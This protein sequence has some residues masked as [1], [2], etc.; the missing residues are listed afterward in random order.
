MIQY[1]D[2]DI[3]VVISLS[4]DEPDVCE[5]SM[6]LATP[7]VFPVHDAET[8][9]QLLACQQFSTFAKLSFLKSVDTASMV[10]I[11]NLV[12]GA[13]AA[14]PLDWITSDVLS[15][16]FSDLLSTMDKLQ[17]ALS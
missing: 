10:H 9:G 12:Q 11:A 13:T 14:V 2:R 8:C 5:F 15:S 7:C 4:D 1:N 3:N 6:R 16:V 17:E